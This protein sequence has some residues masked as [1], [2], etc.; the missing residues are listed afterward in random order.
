MCQQISL[1]GV[2]DTSDWFNNEFSQEQVGSPPQTEYTHKDIQA[3]K[4]YFIGL[5]PHM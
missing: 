5:R 3:L 4:R 2:V 1:V